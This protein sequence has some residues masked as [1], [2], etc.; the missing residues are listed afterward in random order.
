MVVV[1]DA[2]R[3]TEDFVPLANSDVSGRVFSD[4]KPTEPVIGAYGLYVDYWTQSDWGRYVLNFPEQW[5][6]RYFHDT[7]DG[8]DRS[9]TT[10]HHATVQPRHLPHF[11][12]HRLETQ[13]ME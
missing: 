13:S 3:L 7:Y 12:R 4:H 8:N 1:F 2:P 6:R 9:V 10:G 5:V 11:R